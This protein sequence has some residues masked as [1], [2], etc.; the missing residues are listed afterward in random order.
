MQRFSHL[1]RTYTKFK[2]TENI[3]EGEESEITIRLLDKDQDALNYNESQF[4]KS[5][6]RS[7]K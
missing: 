1:K 6:K 4:Y 3:I 2:E 5:R 7:R